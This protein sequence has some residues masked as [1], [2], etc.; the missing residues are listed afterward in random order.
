MIAPAQ[1]PVLSE[2]ECEDLSSEVLGTRH[3]MTTR[4]P[5][6]PKRRHRG[7][8]A[9]PLFPLRQKVKGEGKSPGGLFKHPGG[10]ALLRRRS[11]NQKTKCCIQTQ[12]IHARGGPQERGGREEEGGDDPMWKDVHS[13]MCPLD[14]R[15]FS[16]SAAGPPPG[17]LVHPWQTPF[18]GRKVIQ[19]KK[20]PRHSCCCCSFV[21]IE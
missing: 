16:C 17:T 13:R 10:P 11:K 14:R 12:P 9:S 5:E 7:S 4:L 15:D 20:T 1:A 2:E 6:Q 3:P 19:K 21:I 8:W 18:F